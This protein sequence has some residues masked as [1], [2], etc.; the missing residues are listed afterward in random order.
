MNQCYQINPRTGN[1]IFSGPKR[2]PRVV[3]FPEVMVKV[4]NERCGGCPSSTCW[5]LLLELI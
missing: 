1:Q 4:E 2:T 5:P 3:L